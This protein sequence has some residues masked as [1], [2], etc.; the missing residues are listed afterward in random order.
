M[1]HLPMHITRHGYYAGL[2]IAGA[3]S[4]VICFYLH[5]RGAI[6]LPMQTHYN[7]II[8]FLMGH[9]T[10]VSVTTCLKK[11]DFFLSASNSARVKKSWVESEDGNISTA[12][13]FALGTSLG[14]VLLL[15]AAYDAQGKWSHVGSGGSAGQSD[16][17]GAAAHPSY[18]A[19]R[20]T[21][22]GNHGDRIPVDSIT[23]TTIKE[24]SREPILQRDALTT[25]QVVVGCR[26]GSTRL[27]TVFPFREMVDGYADIVDT[28]NGDANL[29]AEKGNEGEEEEEDKEKEVADARRR[30]LWN[31]EGIFLHHR[32]SRLLR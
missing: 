23:L 12:V 10:A 7:W 24:D 16:A 11:G 29:K 13:L 30:D 14:T 9:P 20:H 25:L 17:E 3:G 22:L 1:L 28:S 8:L 4:A 2:Y 21:L 26:D 27:F 31:E 6:V 18:S 5:S 32:G 19:A 15:E